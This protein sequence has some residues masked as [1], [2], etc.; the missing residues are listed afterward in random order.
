MRAQKNTHLHFIQ[1]VIVGLTV[2]AVALSLGGAFGLLSGR[3]VLAGM[4]SAAIYPLITSAIGGTKI[5]CSGPTGPMTTVFIALMISASQSVPQ[6]HLAG[7]LNLTLFLMATILLI[8]GVLR[9]GNWVKIVPNVVI[10]GFMDGIA[11]I[12]WISQGKKLLQI[13]TPIIE[14]PMF[15]NCLVA[16]ITLAIALLMTRIA[17]N[18]QSHIVGLLSGTLVALV[19]MTTACTL[20]DLPIGRAVPD[21]SLHSYSELSAFAANHS[22]A[23][24]PWHLFWLAL[25]WALQLAVVAYLDTLL[26]SLIIDRE[27]HQES[28]RNRELGAQ[29]IATSLV[30]IVGGIPGAQATER[31]VLML[32]EGAQTRLAG[33]LVG[34]FSLAGVL[35]LQDFVSLIPKAVFAGILLKVGYDVFDWQ[36]IILYFKQWKT[37]DSK[38][39]QPITHEEIVIIFLT[40]GVTAI[41]NVM[42]AV[43]L[44][45]IMFIVLRKSNPVGFHDLQLQKETEGFTDEP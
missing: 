3:G 8:A 35:L 28:K 5:Q 2:S 38:S 13:G 32:K 43:I 19:V 12:I 14:G 20:L 4:L 22:P 6:Q 16:I 42:A 33:I 11:L 30:A 24:W 17:K 27:T 31:S 40:A 21:I 39:S 36:P 41:V 44:C 18:V 15:L 26:T 23:L 7:F 37:T 10:S 45:T 34:V 1:E 29:G 25:P 9:L